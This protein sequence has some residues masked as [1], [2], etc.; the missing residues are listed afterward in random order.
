MS[1]NPQSATIYDAN[2]SVQQ[3]RAMENLAGWTF[4]AT[5]V[6][7]DIGSGN[8]RITANIA[9]HVTQGKIIG[10]DID[11][12]MVDFAN[13]KYSETHTNLIFQ[14]GDACALTFDNEFTRI[15][16]F[17]TLSWIPL[18]RHQEIFTGISVALKP[19]GLA[20]LRM[21]AVG[22][23]PFNRAMDSIC[24]NTKWQQYFCNYVSPAA[25][26]SEENLRL[27]CENC[28]LNVVR[29]EDSTKTSSFKSKYE[30]Q[31]WLMTW[32]PQRHQVPKE[33]VQE[34]VSD[35]IDC[36]CQMMN[37]S[38]EISITLPGLLI[39]ISKI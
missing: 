18:D 28:N 39:E 31:T 26:E 24:A 7:L 34:F 27:I 23:R 14:Q 17:A 22:D 12:D 2:A 4:N 9:S 36:Y 5:D 32:I 19:G 11:Q 38:E 8:G 10:L 1:A 37:F 20:L 30:F 21:S 16:S 25:Y 33:S 35:V 29:V 15:V 6:V 3:Q 13:N